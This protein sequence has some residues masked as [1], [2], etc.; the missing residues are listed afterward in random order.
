M[1]RLRRLLRF[2]LVGFLMGR[3]SE[4]KARSLLVRNELLARAYAITLTEEEERTNDIVLACY[5]LLLLA[6]SPLSTLCLMFE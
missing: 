3:N 6:Y 2:L 5:A 1:M 4:R